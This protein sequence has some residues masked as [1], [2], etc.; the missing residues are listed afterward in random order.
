MKTIEIGEATNP[1]SHY[2]P[3]VQS[4]PLVITDKGTPTAVILALP[5]AD[6]ETVA[7]GTNP[8]FLALIERSRARAH[9]E[10]ELSAAEMR[11]RV[12]DPA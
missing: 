5:N 7:L 2:L 11:R 1:L 12:L 9:E 4:E 6:L 10:G 8:A 3:G